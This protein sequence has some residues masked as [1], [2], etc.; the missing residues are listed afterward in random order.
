MYSYDVQD[1]YEDL[2]PAAWQNYPAIYAA[3]YPSL[4]VQDLPKS[5]G[6]QILASWSVRNRDNVPLFARLTNQLGNQARVD[7]PVVTVPAGATIA[8][9]PL[10]YT[11]TGQPAGLRSG[12]VNIVETTS[13][14]S[15]I[16]TV[17]SHGYTALISQAGLEAVGDPAIT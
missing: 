16:R 14:G 13:G 5:N 9:G 11:V 10:S 4:H 1:Y 8:L 17:A 2:T 12:I 6:S 15:T 7:G 3:A